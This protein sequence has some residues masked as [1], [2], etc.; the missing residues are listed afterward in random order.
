MGRVGV[1]VGFG[2]RGGV[3]VGVG[4][5]AKGDDGGGWGCCS[6]EYSESGADECGLG[7][8]RRDEFLVSW[9]PRAIVTGEVAGGWYEA[10]GFEEAVGDGD[11]ELESAEDGYLSQIV[12]L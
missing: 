11:G 8:D 10:V 9:E 4:V 1:G 5:G 6:G 7:I 12:L 3:G 2:A